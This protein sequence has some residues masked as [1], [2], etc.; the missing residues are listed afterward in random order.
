M[1][2]TISAVAVAMLTTTYLGACSPQSPSKEAAAAPEDSQQ[3]LKTLEDR[4]SY[5]YGLDLASKFKAEGIELN[6]AQMAAAME[7]V[8]KNGEKKMSVGEVAATMDMFR[9]VHLKE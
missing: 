1:K 6:V 5:A 4:F 7:A 9:E 2:R 3:E 8:F